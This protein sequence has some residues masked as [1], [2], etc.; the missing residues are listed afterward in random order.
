M[1]FF[2][3][4]SHRIQ[5]P[6]IKRHKCDFRNYSQSKLKEERRNLTTNGKNYR[7]CPQVI[8]YMETLSWFLTCNGTK[9]PKLCLCAVKK[10]LTHSLTLELGVLVIFNLGQVDPSALFSVTVCMRSYDTQDT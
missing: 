2:A 7:N 6:I 10:L 5:F 9:W 3:V 8:N 4:K 1:Y